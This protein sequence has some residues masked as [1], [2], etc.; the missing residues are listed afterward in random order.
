MEWLGVP[1]TGNGLALQEVG[2]F[3]D[4]TVCHQLT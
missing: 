4:K 2:D 1:N 3:E